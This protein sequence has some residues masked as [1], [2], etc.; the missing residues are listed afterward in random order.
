MAKVIDIT[1]R[2]NHGNSL[3]KSKL[4]PAPVL[5]MTGAREEMLKKERRDVKRTILTEFIGASIILPDRGLLKVSLYDISETGVAF[6]L[7]T[8]D[9]MF[10]EGDEVAMRVYLNHTTYFPF[11]VTVTNSRFIENEGVV[12][13]G[14][15]FMKDTINDVALHHFVKFIENVS[16]A[17][18]RDGGDILVS[19]IS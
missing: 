4:N 19:N 15:Q 1:S 3:K 5:D 18:R 10:V 7:E 11:T 12:R 14:T 16:A 17:L 13:H 8:S 2:V 6:D 9:G